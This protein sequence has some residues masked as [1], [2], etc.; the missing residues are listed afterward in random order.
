MISR[1]LSSGFN[2]IEYF[3]GRNCRGKKLLRRVVNALNFSMLNVAGIN[4]QE[5]WEI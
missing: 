3:K 1:R 2:L 5:L 4:F